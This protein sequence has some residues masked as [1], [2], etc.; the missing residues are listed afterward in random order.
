MGKILRPLL[1]LTCVLMTGAPARAHEAQAERLTLV[2]R[3]SR[4]LTLSF[5]LDC[6]TLLHRALAPE[7]PAAEFILELSARS[8]ADLAA[9]LQRAHAR[10]QA[11]VRLKSPEGQ[12]LPIAQWHWPTP[13]QVQG[14]LQR[15]V[16]QMMVAPQDHDH[17]PPLEVRAELVSAKALTNG[18]RLQLPPELGRVLVVSYRP[19]QRWLEPGATGQSI[20]F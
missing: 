13:R 4:H 10:L 20:E 16:M 7:R 6:A 8:E 9:G 5:Q 1:L 11:G 14:C 12:V 18:V 15:K 19:N 3:E 17:E 2:L